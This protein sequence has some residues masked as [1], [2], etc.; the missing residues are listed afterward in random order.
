MRFDIQNGFVLSVSEASGEKEAVVPAGVTGLGQRALADTAFETVRLPEGLKKIESGA[1]AGCAALREL[2]LPASVQSVS[3]GA[4]SGCVA[5]ARVRLSE[6]MPL[7]GEQLFTGCT[8]LRRAEGTDSGSWAEYEPKTAVLTLHQ[9]GGWKGTVLAGLFVDS[10]LLRSGT[11]LECLDEAGKRLWALWLPVGE[12]SAELKERL[13][14]QLYSAEPFRFAAL[15]ELFRSLKEEK[16][17][18]LYALLRLL[19]PLELSGEVEIM[20]RNLLR[21]WATACARYLVEDGRLE[22]LKAG[23]EAGL[24][25]GADQAELLPL[26]EEKGC[27]GELRELFTGKSAAEAESVET[28]TPVQIKMLNSPV[29]ARLMER[30]EKLRRASLERMAKN[31]E[32]LEQLLREGVRADDRAKVRYYLSGSVVDAAVLYECA[33]LAIENDDIYMLQDLIEAM[34]GLEPMQAGL[35]LEHAAVGGKTGVVRFLCANL[36]EIIPFNRALGYALRQA[37]FDMA[38]AILKREDQKLTTAKMIRD[39]YVA[40]MNKPEQAELERRIVDLGYIDY[41]YY[42]DDF[43]YML[44]NTNRNGLIGDEFYETHYTPVKLAGTE[45]RITFIRRMKE[46]GYFGDKELSYL[47]Y[48][49]CDA[50]EIA[51]AQALVELGAPDFDVKRCSIEAN[52]QTVLEELGDMLTSNPARPSDEKFAFILSRLKPGEKMKMQVK[53]LLKTA[54]VSRALA[55][56]KHSSLENV[57]D[58]PMTIDYFV[59]HNSLEAVELFCQWGKADDCFEAARTLENTEIVAWILDYQNRHGTRADIQDRFEL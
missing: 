19:Y 18:L 39:V 13:R 14:D 27:A 26:A 6:N 33:L 31:G 5:L 47:C 59:R 25:D 46:A 37:S 44:L 8:A 50:D 4:F 41:N 58:V 15:D 1:L 21:R 17:K 20:L 42:D 23:V 43:R 28:L 35:L 51:I 3:A 56:L 2:E 11:V 48:L 52:Q 54:N 40:R 16:N 22:L 49:A 7:Y 53:Y 10:A 36:A 38:D 12:Q 57:E 45:E 24:L 30:K 29:Y 9:L 34:H 55:I 32:S